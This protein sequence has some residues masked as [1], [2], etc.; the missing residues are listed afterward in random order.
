[1]DIRCP[2]C[3]EPW[4]HDELHE[5][6]DS[7]GRHVPYAEASKRF[8]SLGCAAFDGA[9]CNAPTDT[10]TATKAAAVYSALSDDMDGAAAILDDLGI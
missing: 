4:D 1:M 2:K 5:M 6:Y 3:G 8:R 10:E 7:E 9:S